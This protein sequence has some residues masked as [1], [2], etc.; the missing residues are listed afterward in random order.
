[1]N[2]GRILATTS[3]LVVAHQKSTMKAANHGRCIVN[4]P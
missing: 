2:E 1:M 3:Q 4:S